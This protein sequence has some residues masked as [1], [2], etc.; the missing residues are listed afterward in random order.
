METE[1]NAAGPH[2]ENDELNR[3]FEKFNALKS[4]DI[5]V[6]AG[7]IPTSLP[8]DIYERIAKKLQNKNVWK[9]VKIKVPEE[10]VSENLK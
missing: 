6:L 8:S 4:G 10:N 7:S 1:I 2:I 9:K 3:L 5:L